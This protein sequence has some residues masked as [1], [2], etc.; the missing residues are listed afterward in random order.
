MNLVKQFRGLRD[1]NSGTSHYWTQRLTAIAL[2]PLGLWFIFST[3]TMTGDNYYEYKEWLGSPINVALMILLLLMLFYHMKLG[4]ET[5]I[6]DYVHNTKGKFLLLLLNK[7]AAI[8]L[9]LFGIFSLL[10]LGFES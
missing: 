1:V 3:L 4:L 2:A 8:C 6:E 10:I 7:I 5:I 9:A